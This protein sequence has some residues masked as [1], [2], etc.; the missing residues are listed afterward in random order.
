MASARSDLERTIARFKRE[1]AQANAATSRTLI[2]SYTRSWVEIR[3]SLDL[4][5]SQIDT[6]R[7]A[8]QQVNATWLYQADRLRGF[9]SQIGQQIG[10]FAT[11]AAQTTVTA[12][13]HAAG[14]AVV[15]TETYLDKILPDRVAGVGTSFNVPATAAVEQ[16]V[17]A[18]EPGSP[19]VRLFAELGP[20]AVRG[21]RSVLT[22]A[23]TAGWGPR[24]T[25]QVLRENLG[26]NLTRALTVAR[27][28]TIRAYRGATTETLAANRR[29]VDGWVWHADLGD[30]TCPVCW[31]MHGTH[32]KVGE[33]L[34]G[35]PNCRCVMI[36]E[37]KSFKDLGVD[38][39][40]PDL[41][42]D[43]GIGQFRDASPAVQFKVLGPSKFAAYRAGQL[44][45]R[46]LVERTSSR[47]W[48][49]MRTEKSLADAIGRAEAN[50]FIR[51]PS[52]RPRIGPTEGTPKG[53]VALGDALIK[54]T[55][56][57][58]TKIVDRALALVDTVHGDGTLPFTPIIDSTRR[59]A[60]AWYTP[61]RVEIS[62]R[63]G[64]GDSFSVIHEL[65][66]WLDHQAI[67]GTVG[68]YSSQILDTPAIRAWWNVVTDSDHWA[69]VTR[70]RPTRPA[71]REFR[72]YLLRPRELW[73]RSYSQYVATKTADPMVLAQLADFRNAGVG[74][75]LQWS[76]QDFGPVG[77]A[78]EAVL[79]SQGWLR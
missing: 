69:E 56:T 65:G 47:A 51:A 50:K 26:G 5:T 28:E 67:G 3:R 22:T 11:G 10:R 12:Q 60:F 58:T 25:A 68:S 9:E 33:P 43:P 6:A 37:T 2:D 38:V 62:I 72:G 53:G 55:G 17:G 14:A 8:G 23:V 7:A 41:G 59:D 40:E 18:L 29:V 73:A 61:G 48:G 71:A 16:V 75:P 49:P 70:W 46:D 35:H 27:T 76:D 15:H 44:D 78:V 21:A 39:V 45:L 36:P 54:Q 24:Q 66:H 57:A 19:L 77:E 63:P 32:H 13:G 79:H 4:L 30:R 1:L 64:R 74:V 31:A 20:D 42:I 52:A 34:D